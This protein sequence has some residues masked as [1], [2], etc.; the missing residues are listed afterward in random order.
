MELLYATDLV[1][2]IESLKYLKGKPVAW[3]PV[4]KSRELRK[5][6]VRLV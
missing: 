2:L 5:Y 4:L 6:E 1:L 3:K